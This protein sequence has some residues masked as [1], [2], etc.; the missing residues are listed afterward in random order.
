VPDDGFYLSQNVYYDLQKNIVI[1]VVV[2]DLCLSNFHMLQ[3][4]V[5][6]VCHRLFTNISSLQ[7]Y[8]LFLNF[9]SHLSDAV[10]PPLPKFSANFTCTYK[11]LAH[12]LTDGD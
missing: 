3:Q 11:Q 6:P 9:S 12:S 4:D 2:I 1:A 5:S 10:S 7:Q 8:R